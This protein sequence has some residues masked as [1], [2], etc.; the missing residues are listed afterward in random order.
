MNSRYTEIQVGPAFSEWSNFLTV[1]SLDHSRLSELRQT[2]RSRLVE[3][4]QAFIL[5]LNAI[6]EETELTVNAAPLLTGDPTTQPIV[7][8]GHQP[9]QFHSGLSF[10]YETTQQFAAENNAIA[11]AVIIDTDRGDAGQFS[12]PDVGDISDDRTSD[13]N[14]RPYQAVLAVDSISN[15]NNLFGHGKLKSAAELKSLGDTVSNSLKRLA[16]PK[17]AALAKKVFQEFAQLSTAK[18]SAMEANTIMRWQYGIGNQMLELPLSA[19][20]SFPESMMLTVDILKQPNRFAAAYN[21][22]L[23]LFREEHSIQNSANPF[24]NLKINDHGCELPFW[25][26]DHNRGTRQVLEVH[27]DG[28]VTRL[29]ANGVTVDTLA[30]NI[31]DDSLE[32]MLLQNL[33][34]VPRGALITVFLRLLFSDLFVHGTGG[35]RYDR[36]TDEFIR[37]W[38]NAEPPPFTVASASRYLFEDQRAELQRLQKIKSELRDLQFNPQ[39]HFGQ[40]VF[41]DSLEERLAVLVQKKTVAVAELKAMKEAGESGKETGQQIQVITNEIRE[42]VAAEFDSQLAVLNGLTP[43]QHDA[44]NSRTYPWFFFADSD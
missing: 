17:A 27:V 25:V 4:A 38:W 9:V 42:A 12:Y 26:V 28:N 36:F 16:K 37:T 31:S 20:A 8:T 11:V 15:S 19:I 22:A 43:E 1:S 21:S 35:G 5:R 6:A 32:P 39:R 29:L 2:A 23:A 30:D 13:E 40:G 41:S 18:A 7:M 10:K 33:Q 3:S 44:I 14:V 24:P 34:L